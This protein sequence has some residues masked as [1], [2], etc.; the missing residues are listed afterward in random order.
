METRLS[1]EYS[2]LPSRRRFLV[3]TGG[4]LGGTGLACRLG[5]APVDGVTID[6]V[7]PL[8]PRPTHFKARAKSIIWLSMHGGISQIDTFDHKPELEKRDRQSVPEAWIKNRRAARGGQLM[9]SRREWKAYGES[10]H[11][12]SDLF[13]HLA[14]QVDNLCFIHSL[15]TENSNHTPATFSMNMGVMTGHKPSVGAWVNYALGSENPDLP[16]FVILYEVGP[17]GGTSNWGTSF[18]PGSFQGTRFQS[19]GPIVLDLESPPGLELLGRPTIDIA[20]RLNRK[21]RAKRPGRLDLD[22]RIASYE[23]AHRMQS[24]AAKLGDLFGETEETR[25]LYGLYCKPTVERFARKC[26]LARRLIERGVRFRA[27]QQRRA[28]PG[29]LGWP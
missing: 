22:A 24:S 18:L 5:A 7:F 1:L 25:R 28:T 29:A 13:P 23:L 11:M 15:H 17:L 6:P 20:Q 19:S 9:S 10:G 4:V 8:K 14:Q 3:A 27:R 16:G 12:V 2:R 26:L 21:H